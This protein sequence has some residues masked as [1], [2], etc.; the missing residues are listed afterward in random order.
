MVKTH[1]NGN[2]E[3]ILNHQVLREMGDGTGEK[4]HLW[5]NYVIIGKII[6]DPSFVLR[7]GVAGKLALEGAVPGG[8]GVCAVQ[9]L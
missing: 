7:S 3:H 2:F 5:G 4:H 9:G 6:P 1:S 8:C